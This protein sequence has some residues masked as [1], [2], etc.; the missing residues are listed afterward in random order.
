MIRLVI[1]PVN[2]KDDRFDA[3]LEAMLTKAPHETPPEPEP[4]ND[5]SP[6]HPVKGDRG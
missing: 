2:E 4:R 1:L 6:G 5:E 3:L